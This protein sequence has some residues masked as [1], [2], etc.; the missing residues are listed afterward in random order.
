MEIYLLIRHGH[1]IIDVGTGGGG[2]GGGG[3]LQLPPASPL[4]MQSLYNGLANEV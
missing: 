3:A 1:N 4:S 2:G